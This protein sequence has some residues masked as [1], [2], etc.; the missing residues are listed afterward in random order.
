[1]TIRLPHNA[2][3]RH[4]TVWAF[5]ALVVVVTYAASRSLYTA[6]VISAFSYAVASSGLGYI[7]GQAGMLSMAQAGLWGIGAF[8]AA[9]ATD[10]WGWGFL[11]SCLVAI[12]LCTVAG[13]VLAVPALRVKGHYFLIITFIA[14]LLLVT[15]G[16]NVSVTG[17]AQGR[18]I[19]DM[20][21]IFGWTA[22]TPTAMLIMFG[23]LYAI[24]ASVLILL[25]RTRSGRLTLLVRENETLAAALGV[26]VAAL[27]FLAFAIS[28]AFAG[29]G[30]A[31]YAYFIQAIAPE[32]FGL[33]AATMLAAAV[34]VGGARFTLGPLIGALI[35]QLVPLLL[36]F[37]PTVSA[38]VN[39]ALLVVIILVA[40]GGVAG[41]A[42]RLGTLLRRR[43]VPVPERDRVLEDSRS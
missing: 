20:P 43:R 42:A 25:K 17:G 37:S 14:T 15:V 18:V 19:A 39:G 36:G 28:G 24:A 31:M 8:V 33:G 12:V 21:S 38:G 35:I 4:L 22:D 40:S 41:L 3:A 23:V 34:I 6:T 2:F 29:L 30:G 10:D 9:I 26:N 11:T 32:T 13:L 16:T 7:Y 1:M 5:V 27:K